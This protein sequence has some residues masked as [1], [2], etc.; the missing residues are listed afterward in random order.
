[1]TKLQQLLGMKSRD[2]SQGRKEKDADYLARMVRE[3][4]KRQNFSA[5]TFRFCYNLG[6]DL[7]T[8]QL[9]R[10]IAGYEYPGTALDRYSELELSAAS[11]YMASHVR[12][13]APKSLDEIAHLTK[14]NSDRIHALN[15]E[16]YLAQQ[17]LKDA[18]WHDIFGGP[19]HLTA[20]EMRRTLSFP[21]LKSTGRPT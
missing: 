6:L 20:V 15:T 18:Q 13:A 11:V 21:P 8:A 4:A 5:L 7:S 16:F 19:R 14:V 12:G 17:G 10:L 3:N 9:A 2:E 1:M